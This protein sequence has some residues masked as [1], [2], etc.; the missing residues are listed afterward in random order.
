[1]EGKKYDAGKDR[2]DLLPFAQVRQIVKVLTFG[3]AKYE[4][5]N[6]QG[7]EKERYIAAAFRHLTAWI[8][9]ERCDPESGIHHLAHAACNLLFLLWQDDNPKQ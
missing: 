9:G 8:D 6:W 3:A 7:V 1:M 5:N 2:W 4:P